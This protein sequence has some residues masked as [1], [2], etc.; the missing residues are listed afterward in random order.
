[1]LPVMIMRI[2]VMSVKG[3]VKS[4]GVLMALNQSGQPAPGWTALEQEVAAGGR[5]HEEGFGHCQAGSCSH[6]RAF[7]KADS[8]T[9]SS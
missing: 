2:I 9:L 8:A 1:M 6:Q 3:T 5:P 7:S 4:G